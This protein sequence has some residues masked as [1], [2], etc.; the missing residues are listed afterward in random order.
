MDFY[1]SEEELRRERAKAQEPRQSRWWQKRIARGRCPFCGA[2]GSPKKLTLDHVLPLVRGGKSTR[3]NCVPA[4]KECN[5]RKQH[6][7]PV[8]WEEYLAHLASR[9]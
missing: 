1:V 6:L 4:C 5:S 2:Q 8:E 7:L 9:H 3:G